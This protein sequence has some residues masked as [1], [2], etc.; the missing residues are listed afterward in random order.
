MRLGVLPSEIGKAI[1]KAAEEALV[2]RFDDQFL[3]DE[4]QAGAGTSI[5]MNVNEVLANRANELLGAELGTYKYVHPNNHVNAQQS[6]NDVVPSAL[7]I[8]TLWK[9]EALLSELEELVRGFE[10]KGREFRDIVKAGRTHLMDAVPV[11]L[12]QCFDTY[13]ASIKRNMVQLNRCKTLLSELPLGGTAVGTGLNSHPKFPKIAV[14][15]LSEVTALKLRVAENKM[16]HMQFFTDFGLCSSSLAVLASDL[17]KIASDLRLLASGPHTGLGEIMLPAVQPGSSIMPAKIN[18]SMPEALNMVC[19]Q[20][21]ANNLGVQL[22]CMEGQ[23]E[24]NVFAPVVAKN[25]LESLEIMKNALKVFR[26]RCVEGLVADAQKCEQYFLKSQ[27]LV[28]LVAPMIGYDAAAELAK[29]AEKQKKSIIELVVERNILSEEELKRRLDKYKITQP[30]L[31]GT[32][33]EPERS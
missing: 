5:N 28:T 10:R 21:V 22:A 33:D 3:I 24:L 20:T 25:L 26:E 9:L 31:E 30:N 14:A 32:E 7:R 12:G 8:A 2:G 27:A 11:L 18:P 6:S 1:I 16:Q 19:F 29:E 4:F 23:L 15:K 17:S 13:A